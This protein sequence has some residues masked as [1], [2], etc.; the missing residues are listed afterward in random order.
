MTSGLHFV[1]ILNV[2]MGCSPSLSRWFGTCILFFFSTLAKQADRVHRTSPLSFT[3]CCHIRN[4]SR[5]K[6]ECDVLKDLTSCRSQVE[7]NYF[8]YVRLGC[9]PSLINHERRCQN[10]QNHLN[11]STRSSQ[12]A[13]LHYCLLVINAEF[14]LF[15]YQK[16]LYV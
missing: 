2:I 9:H 8:L 4:R 12:E 5:Y 16:N 14:A 1:D 10:H 6:P 15:Y 13:V 3:G 11:R 7:I